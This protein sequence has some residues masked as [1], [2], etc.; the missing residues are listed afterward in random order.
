MSCWFS[1]LVLVPMRCPLSGC[2]ACLVKDAADLFFKLGT[3][4]LDN[5]VDNGVDIAAIGRNNLGQRAAFTGLLQDFLYIKPGCL[6]DGLQRGAAQVD[7]RCWAVGDG[8]AIT[9][10]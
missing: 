4:L 3:E 10:A 1:V 6:A 7:Y 2:R 9:E 5:R 8:L